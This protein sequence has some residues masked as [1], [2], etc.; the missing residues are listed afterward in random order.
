M[1]PVSK[2]KDLSS[3]GPDMEESS[4]LEYSAGIGCCYLFCKAPQ[5]IALMVKFMHISIA[6]FSQ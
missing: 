1:L 4:F 2:G 3:I 6:L 5:S